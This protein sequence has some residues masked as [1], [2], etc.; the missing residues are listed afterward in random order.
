[1]ASAHLDANRADMPE[2]SRLGL[3]ARL[4]AVDKARPKI[5][6]KSKHKSKEIKPD[7]S[8]K[9]AKDGKPK[10]KDSAPESRKPV[11]AA[12]EKPKKAATRKPAAPKKKAAPVAGISQDDIALRAYYIGEERRRTG[13]SG[14]SHG[15]WLEAERQLRSEIS[16]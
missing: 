15:D 4:R 1:M 16:A 5:M 14:S 13:T 9:P 12:V 6:S 10:K 11:K 8:E 7:K 3:D 2:E